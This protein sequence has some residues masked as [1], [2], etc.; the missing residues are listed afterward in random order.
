VDDAVALGRI[1]STLLS[2]GSA[3]VSWIEFGEGTSE[4]RARR[5]HPDGTK[6]GS[7]VVTGVS[8]ERASGYPRLTRSGDRVYFAWTETRPVRRVNMAVLTGRDR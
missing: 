5:I 6:D 1:D 7:F 4:V 3:L 2:D 8:S